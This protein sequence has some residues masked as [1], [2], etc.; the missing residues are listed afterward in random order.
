MGGDY[1]YTLQIWPYLLTA[2]LLF[3]LA[4]FSWRRRTVPGALPFAVACLFALAWVAG[5]AAESMALEPATK[6]AWFK[7]QAVWQLPLVTAVTCFILDYA[8]PGRWLT[9]RTLACAPYTKK[10]AQKP[11]C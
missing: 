7:F 11:E 1:A 8:N 4:A 10:I 3:A 6:I 5:A 2:A 9:R